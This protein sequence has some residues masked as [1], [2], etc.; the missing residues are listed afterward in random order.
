M[1][2]KFIEASAEARAA[3]NWQIEKAEQLQQ[4]QD[5]HKD[6]TVIARDQKELDAS[7]T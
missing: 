7:A 5:E 2:H 1:A 4:D 3:E 6:A